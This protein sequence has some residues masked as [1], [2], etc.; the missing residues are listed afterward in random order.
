MSDDLH[1]DLDQIESN[2]R[3]VRVI[4]DSGI[5]ISGSLMSGL[6]VDMDVAEEVVTTVV[7]AVVTPG[8]GACCAEDLTCSI[9]TEADC[10]G[11]YQ[12]DDTVCDPNPCIITGAC[13]VD[14]VC[15]IETESDCTDM[16]GTYQGDDTECD[17]NPCQFCA[18]TSIDLTTRIYGSYD[19]LPDD[20][21]AGICSFSFDAT[22]FRNYVRVVSDPVAGEFTVDGLDPDCVI[23][24]PSDH[25]DFDVSALMFDCADDCAD[26]PLNCPPCDPHPTVPCTTDHI[27]CDYV[28]MIFHISSNFAGSSWTG[29]VGC[30]DTTGEGE[31]CEPFSLVC[32]TGFSHGPEDETIVA[33]AGTYFFTYSSTIN[34][35]TFN[36]E[37]TLVLS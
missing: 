33:V 23:N 24:L 16:S 9:T 15:T 1:S 36:F 34:G 21:G 29:R 11:T 27:D 4:G 20:T 10:V 37:V 32:G 13:C 14:G 2:I 3:N 18:I 30:D 28:Q 19:G 26:D 7:A 25:I 31:D 35:V 5:R 12:G 22:E 17:P 8:T 6:K